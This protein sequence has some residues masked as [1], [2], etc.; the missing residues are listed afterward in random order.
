MSGSHAIEWAGEEMILLPERAVW[1]PRQEAL[2]LADVH[3]GKSATFRAHGIPVPEGESQEDLI[4][5]SQLLERYPARRLVVAGDFFHSAAPLMPWLDDLL[6]EWLEKLGPELTLVRGNHDPVRFHEIEMT[7]V[8]QLGPFLVIHDPA[9]A[10]AGR[11][12]IAGHLHPL[13][14]IGR[15][16]R[17][18]RV[19]C[20]VQTGSVLTVPAFGTFT[21]GSLVQHDKRASFFPVASGKVY[22]F[23]NCP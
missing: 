15:T 12:S 18:S 20:F 13:C 21:S 10:P 16:G 5:I 22:A 14:R 7:T 1:W 11:P 6:R 8:L 3:F 17:A 23:R 2:I 9:A 4:R 19:P